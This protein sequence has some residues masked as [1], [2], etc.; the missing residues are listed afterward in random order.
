MN[1]CPI[2]CV[3]CGEPT[4]LS[5]NDLDHC[6]P[7]CGDQCNQVYHQQMES[8]WEKILERMPDAVQ[9]QR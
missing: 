6:P 1:D 4:G 7:V 5:D 8:N 9:S 3:I 2:K